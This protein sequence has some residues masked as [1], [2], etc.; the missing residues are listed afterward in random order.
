MSGHCAVEIQDRITRNVESCETPEG[1][2]G[3]EGAISVRK[4]RKGGECA[5]CYPGG[6]KRP[7]QCIL[8]VIAENG[9]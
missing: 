2:P 4:G 9:K 7:A 6:W 5:Q 1:V 3:L 8:L